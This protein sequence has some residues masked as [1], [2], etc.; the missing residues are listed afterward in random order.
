[1]NFLKRLFATQQPAQTLS[2]PRRSQWNYRL[3]EPEVVW[4][5]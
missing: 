2:R 3:P 1:M 4:L 5:G